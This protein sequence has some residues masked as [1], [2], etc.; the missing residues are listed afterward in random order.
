MKPLHRLLPAIVTMLATIAIVAPA[1]AH[2]P[3][4]A[5]VY[6]GGPRVSF[7]Y[8]APVW[9]GAPYYYGAPYAHVPPPAAA[10]PA[11]TV[12]IERSDQVVTTM[13]APAADPAQAPASGGAQWWYLCASPRG[14]YPYV[15]ECPGGWERVPA[16]PPAPSR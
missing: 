5:R 15:R 7:Y 6:W 4:G 1:S 2:G 9:W 11:P 12:Y 8:G 14:A 3:G 16:T 13:P 10:P